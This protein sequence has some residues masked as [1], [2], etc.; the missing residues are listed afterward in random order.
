M[1]APWE[2]YQ[3]A[4]PAEE[5]APALA[6]SSEPVAEGPWTKY[7]TPSPETEEKV[8]PVETSGQTWAEEHPIAGRV[9]SALH[10][11]G[12]VI[13][14]REKLSAGLHAITDTGEGSFGEKY[15]KALEGQR[16][17]GEQLTEA[18]PVTHFVGSMAPMLTPV[19]A[20]TMLAGEGAIGKA[21]GKALPFLGETGKRVAGVSGLGGAYGAAQGAAQGDTAEERISNAISGGTLG[22]ALGPVG[23][24]IGAVGRN[25][26][27]PAGKTATQEAAE[28]LGLE[29]VPRYVTSEAP[30]QR[31]ASAGVRAIP[32]AGE[33]LSEAA[34]VLNEDLGKK[35]LSVAGSAAPSAE[36]AGGKLKSGIN[37]WIGE[38]SRQHVSNLYNGV[39]Q[40]FDDWNQANGFPKGVRANH[41]L[42]AT[43]KIF[44]ELARISEEKAGPEI[45]G[46]MKVVKKALD[47]PEGMT[48][49]GIQGLR[50][51]LGDLMGSHQELIAKDVKGAELKRL[52]GALSEDLKSA[53]LNEGGPKALNEFQKAEREYQ[54]INA[55]RNLLKKITGVGDTRYSD[56]QIFSNL[57]NMARGNRGDLR[58][59]QL[60]KN[61]LKPND[62]N[63]VVSNMVH[64][65]GKQEEALGKPFSPAK[66]LT[67]YNKINPKARDV[68]FG[69]PGTG[70]RQNLDDIAL[71]A[72]G[73]GEGGE[74]LNTSK[75]AHVNEFLK[76]LGKLGTIGGAF[77]GANTLAGEGKGSA[78]GEA[79][80]EL[81]AT[82]GGGY[83]LASLLASPRGSFAIKQWMKSGS[84]QAGKA[85]TDEISRIMGA[86]PKAA[87][88]AIQSNMANNMENRE[89]R[90]SGGKVG[91]RDYPAKRL[92]RMEKALKRAQEAIA[93]ETKPLMDK[94]DEAIAAA[95]HIAKDK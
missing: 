88:Y 87:R 60:A 19:G 27:G 79:A 41:Q 83:M 48:F 45:T 46:A 38:D 50:Q 35:I 62:W 11:A 31:M 25:I 91:N 40:R 26:F 75:T 73:I 34:K 86:S 4:S 17:A 84:P 80:A 23:E 3:S 8:P 89:E 90:A 16:K 67:E 54:V 63:F 74:H 85:L 2:N 39:T 44:D 1:A 94:P 42:P 14:G 28:R 33:K 29:N 43:A 92:T 93:L 9:L 13:P 68:L 69:A 81:G 57:A 78:A 49:N 30:T 7:A 56:E 24:G 64:S 61:T 20:E 95:L 59:L 37:K 6:S 65:I 18:Y 32:L 15:E 70:Y 55:K 12:E 47:R 82:V 71:L 66:F 51:D 5:A 53:A 21:A 58:R 22:A 77:Y 52:W 10:G 76:T 36:V 72:K